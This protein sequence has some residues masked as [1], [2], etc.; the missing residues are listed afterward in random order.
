[1]K[2]PC[3]VCETGVIYSSFNIPAC[4]GC[5]K[6]FDGLPMLPTPAETSKWERAHAKLN[7][8]VW[9]PRGRQ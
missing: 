9:V 5:Q 7:K 3:P 2:L 1:M 8:P 6:M 4:K